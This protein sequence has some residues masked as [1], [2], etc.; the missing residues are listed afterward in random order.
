MIPAVED[1]TQKAWAQQQAALLQQQT[2]TATAAAE[3]P[4]AADIEYEGAAATADAA[5][6]ANDGQLE[7]L[8]KLLVT[9]EQLRQKITV[10]DIRTAC[11][12]Q[13]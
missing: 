12:Q 3:E 1:F 7:L 2:S 8:G 4:M 13:H 6:A 9:P 5:A 11:G 10:S